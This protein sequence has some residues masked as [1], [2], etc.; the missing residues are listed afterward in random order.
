M[1]SLRGCEVAGALFV[2]AYNRL[3]PGAR[4]VWEFLVQRPGRVEMVITM[5]M[6]TNIPVS[7]SL[8]RV[9]KL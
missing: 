2:K 3:R 6:K 7:S 8:P 9:T 5:E 1:R 4:P